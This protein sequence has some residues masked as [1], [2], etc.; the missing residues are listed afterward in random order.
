MFRIFDRC[1]VYA[2]G[3]LI[4]L[5]PFAPVE[6][7]QARS[8]KILHSFQGGSDGRGPRGQLIAD[9]AGNFYG[10][11]AY[12]GGGNCSNNWG[13]G[14]VFKLAP[15]GTV[16]V[17]YAFQGGADGYDPQAGLL[18]DKAGNLYGASAGDDGCAYDCGTIFKVAP[19]GTLTTLHTFLGGS[20][21]S[22]PNGAL[23]SDRKGNL[24]GTT[25]YGG[26]GECFNES[27]C[28]TVFMLKTNGKKK[29][30]YAFTGGS[31]GA[32]PGSGLIIDK[33]GNLY[34]T[35]YEGGDMTS[36]SQLGCGT[37]FKVAPDRTETVIYAF[38][39]S[40]DGQMPLG[41][42]TADKEGN[43]YGAT[44]GLY[45]DI[46]KISPDGT[47]TTLY[48]FQDKADGGFPYGPLLVDKK[49]NVYG[50]AMKGG[51]YNPDCGTDKCGTVFKITQDGT[52]HVLYS[53]LGDPDGSTPNGGLF[54]DKLG[55]LYG[56]TFDGGTADIGAVFEIK[57]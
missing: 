54:R 22:N 4:A 33:T 37:V 18:M 11:T 27:G 36:C 40:G 46:F 3:I 25:A 5:A 55:N 30:L 49:S 39:N 29:I 21:G 42:V 47:E 45:G 20:D 48:Q 31:D 34:G 19:D 50:V 15:D 51:L 17:L 10:T 13:C 41:G 7:A 9:G 8:E 14:T 52:E 6:N 26:I 12:G 44:A 43:L 56:A 2:V 32:V 16:T 1:T 38:Q 24:Y 28:G 53:F 35:T 57:K 23:V